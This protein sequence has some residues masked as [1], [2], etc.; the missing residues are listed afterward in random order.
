MHLLWGVCLLPAAR[1]MA[2]PPAL[3]TQG[4][5]EHV[6][7]SQSDG[8][9][10]AS[11]LNAVVHVFRLEPCLFPFLCAL[12]SDPLLVFLSGGAGAFLSGESSFLAHIAAVV[13]FVFILVTTGASRCQRASDPGTALVQGLVWILVPP[14][15]GSSLMQPSSWPRTGFL[16]L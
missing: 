5:G 10:M 12:C 15:L 6:D 8:W 14:A 11:H 2:L 13:P 16:I 4:L 7:F 3:P 1:E 9:R